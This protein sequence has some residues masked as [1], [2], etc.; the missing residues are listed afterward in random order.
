M[1]SGHSIGLLDGAHSRYATPEGENLYWRH[2]SR[3]L[4]ARLARAEKLNEDSA[5]FLQ[6]EQR[7]LDAVGALEVAVPSFAPTLKKMEE[8]RLCEIP[9]APSES[10]IRFNGELVV[11]LHSAAITPDGVDK[12]SEYNDAATSSLRCSETRLV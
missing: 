2:R 12:T 11:A 6:R 10:I 7:H 5:R 4:E 9:S 1:Q 8:L 3:D